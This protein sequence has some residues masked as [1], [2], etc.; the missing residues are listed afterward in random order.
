MSIT[1]TAQKLSI[2]PYVGPRAFRKNELFFG[3]ER[4]SAGLIN[5]LIAG[6]IVLLHSPSGAGKTSLIQ[7]SVVPALEDRRFQVCARLK[8]S[9]SAIRVN[10]PIPEG[11][12]VENRYIYSAVT[13][14]TAHLIPDPGEVRSW[15]I[16]QALD[17]LA[18]QDGAPQRQLLILDQ[19]EEILTLGPTDQ[20]GQRTFFKQVGEA[21]ENHN[22]WALFA[23]REDYMGGLD[24][25]LRYVPGQLRSTFRLDLLDAKAALKAVQ[26]PAKSRGIKFDDEAALTL[27]NDLRR[28]RV[29]TPGVGVTTPLGNYVEPVLLQ[30]VCDSLW[31]NLSDQ[32]NADFR[33]HSALL[34]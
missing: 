25:Y 32:Q 4:E 12:E 34:I 29:E 23:M 7:A 26:L 17:E 18:R 8:P 1:G 22:R 21:L 6:R 16:T 30:V 2:N 13:G 15:S 20:D 19:F 31:R 33:R 9:F 11:L 24:R 14:L 5:T 28:V 27:V 10:A 3:R